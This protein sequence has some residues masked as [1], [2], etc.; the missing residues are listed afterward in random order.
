[1]AQ[2]TK[3]QDAVIAYIALNFTDKKEEQKIKEIFRT[4]SKD[5]STFKI[6]ID[7]FVKCLTENNIATA[8]EAKDIFYSIDND[9]NGSIEYQE[10][11][12]ALSDKE[13]LLSEKNLK[14][15]F[16]FFDVDKSETITWD[17]IARVVFQGKNV[18]K[19]LVNSFL[20]EIGKTEKDPITFK[21]FCEMIR[22]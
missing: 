19:E 21:E 4:M 16:D 18:P 1:M 12:R 22:K 14:E 8:D 7:M 2:K 10:L 20:K 15:A 11:V 6:D 5:H 3:F 17:E 9:K 13:K